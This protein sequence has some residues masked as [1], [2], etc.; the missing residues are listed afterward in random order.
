MSEGGSKSTG[1]TALMRGM[2]LWNMQGHEKALEKLP[3]KVAAMVP[4]EQYFEAME[5]AGLRASNSR[6]I[7]FA[8]LAS[9]EALQVMDQFLACVRHYHVAMK[10]HT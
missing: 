4:K 2:H 10:C 3:S 5:A 7:N 8:E 6:F 1:T 9:I